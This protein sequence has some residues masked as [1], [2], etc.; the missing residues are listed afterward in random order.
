MPLTAAG[1]LL[2]T[3]DPR[4]LIGDKAFRVRDW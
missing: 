1:Q 3:A 4:A 2:E